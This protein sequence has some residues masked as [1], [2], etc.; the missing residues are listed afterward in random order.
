LDY[1]I[2]G[3]YYQTLYERLSIRL[4]VTFLSLQKNLSMKR[5]LSPAQDLTQ[6]ILRDLFEFLDHGKQ[7]K[8]QRK[9]SKEKLKFYSLMS[10]V[11]IAYNGLQY[12]A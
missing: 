12:D 11:L 1:N 9:L 8:T 5:N 6:L 4:N 3:Y 2:E 10:F 7:M